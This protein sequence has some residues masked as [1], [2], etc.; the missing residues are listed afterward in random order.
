MTGFDLAEE[1]LR[2]ANKNAASLGVKIRTIVA[3]DDQ[4]RDLTGHDADIFRRALKPGGIVVYENGA[5]PDNGVLQAF[6][7]FQIVR[8]E[9]VEALS[10]WN[11]TEKH[12]VQKMIARIP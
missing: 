2:I 12:R 7:R 4:L 3:R 1:A 10:D 11:R 8:F 5:S 6:L 9:D